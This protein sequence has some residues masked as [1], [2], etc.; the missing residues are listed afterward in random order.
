MTMAEKH[1]LPPAARSPHWKKINDSAETGRLILQ[2][3]ANCEEVQYP[4]R[5]LC[6]SCLDDRLNWKSVLNTGCLLSFTVLHA[7]HVPF[8]QERTPWYIGLIQ[9]DCGPVIFAHLTS[10]AVHVDDHV[11]VICKRDKSGQGVFVAVPASDDPGEGLRR[12]DHLFRS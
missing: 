10:R 4:P 2:V 1:L 7:S 11:R 9:L 6:G 12:L 5:E 3:C 8:F